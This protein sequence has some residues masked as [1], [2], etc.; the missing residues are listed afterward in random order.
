[1]AQLNEA[2]S[3]DSITGP[4]YLNV[5][6]G[7][8]SFTAG[9][10]VVAN[11]SGALASVPR[12]L[13]G[14]TQG[15]EF[16]G[17]DDYIYIA[18]NAAL[19]VGTND[20]AIS[21]QN[22]LTDW[23]PGST[24]CL[25][26][27][28]D[29][30]LGF[31]LNVTATGLLQLQIGNGT[32][33]TTYQYNSTVAVPLTDMTEGYI[34]VTAD[35]DGVATF[36]VNGFQLGDT[37]DI[38]GSASQTVTNSGE[39]WLMRDGSVYANGRV[40]RFY[41]DNF[42]PKITEINDRFHRGVANRYKYG[43]F[44]NY[45]TANW[46][47]GADSW[48]GQRATVTG[49]QDGVSDGSTSKDNCL[50]I[51]ADNTVSNT[52]FAYRISTVV[53]NRT[54]RIRGSYYIPNTGG[55]TY[56]SG[57]R[58]VVGG[59][60]SGT[61]RADLDT[62]GAWTDFDF[63]F[64]HNSAVADTTLL[65]IVLKKSGTITFTGAN[66]ATDDLV[67][68]N[69]LTVTQIGAVVALEPD[70]TGITSAVWYDSSTNSLNGTT[71]GSP[72]LLNTIKSTPNTFAYFNSS[73]N[74]AQET[75]LSGTWT[76]AI[77]FATPGDLAVTYSTQT[78]QFF[79]IGAMVFVQF[80]I[81][82]SAFTHTTAAGNLRITGLPYTVT[83]STTNTTGNLLDRVN[84][85]LSYDTLTLWGRTGTTYFELYSSNAAGTSAGNLTVTEAATGTNKTLSGS[86]WFRAV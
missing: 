14:V 36:S 85:S 45:Y 72:S 52:H 71:S 4:A 55:T 34:T 81:T 20:F 82:T 37:V 56:L 32:N 42:V 24:M 15:Y 12:P 58:F 47:A 43:S 33:F 69:G 60:S 78:G 25:A 27:K 54:W 2:V 63:T 57:I 9:Y 49:N 19:A 6:I 44:G 41:L 31:K 11:G 5:K 79:R 16:D 65:D 21:V 53:Q 35:R 28:T 23:T 22:S 40:Y 68:I 48:T 18:D 80:Q 51:Y 70:V 39:L 1:M 26:R 38:S 7:A 73:G 13:T 84:V 64:T 62:V 76:P 8:G 50:C 75:Y 29:S 67:Y 17:L 61:S 86:L 10:D 30:N 66:S 59:T 83:G 77:T 3:R 74:Q 46:T